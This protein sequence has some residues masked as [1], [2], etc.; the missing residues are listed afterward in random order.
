MNES[1]QTDD[2]SLA[3]TVPLSIVSLKSHHLVHLLIY[4]TG[5]AIRSHCSPR[6]SV[7]HATPNA[8]ISEVDDWLQTQ[9]VSTVRRGRLIE[10]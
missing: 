2:D 3:V 6:E 4:S 5:F 10:C 9:S 8:E 7:D 1:R